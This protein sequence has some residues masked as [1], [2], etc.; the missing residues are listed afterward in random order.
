MVRNGNHPGEDWSFDVDNVYYEDDSPMRVY[1]NKL[2]L[3]VGESKKVTVYGGGDI[4]V[5]I[6]QYD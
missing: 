6:D 4:N 3:G 1:Q 2:V 5:N